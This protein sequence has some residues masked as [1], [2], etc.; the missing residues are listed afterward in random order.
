MGQDSNSHALVVGGTGMLLGCSLQL[1]Q[2]FSHVSVLARRASQA[3]QSH[4]KLWAIDADYSQ[5]QP[6]KTGIESAVQFH[7][8]IDLI[9]SWVHSSAPDTPIQVAKLLVE[10][11][12]PVDFFDVLGSAFSNPADPSRLSLRKAKFSSIEGLGYHSVVLGFAA[13]ATGS[14]W[15]THKEISDGVFEAI[16]LKQQNFTVGQTE[17]WGERP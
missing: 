5:W 17:P 14:R 10:H 8:P 1:A 6:T 11:Q 3:V 13:E 15:L 9:V 2:T 12:K 16:Q 4:S 7:G